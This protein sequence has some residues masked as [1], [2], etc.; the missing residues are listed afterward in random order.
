VKLELIL[1]LGVAIGLCQVAHADDPASPNPQ[2]LG[3]VEA[4]LSSCA[5]VDPEHA[6]RYQ[7]Q[8]QTLTQGDS[9][10]SVVE[11]RRSEEYKQ[12]YDAA[13]ESIS[14]VAVSDAVKACRKSLAE[15][16]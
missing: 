13:M 15:S 3:T 7:D 1:G 5:H 11:A 14:A 16:K 10:E 6:S 2:A 12:A 9:N 4:I 8:V